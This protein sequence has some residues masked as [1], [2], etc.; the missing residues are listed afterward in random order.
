[1]KYL[2]TGGAG[3]IGSNIAEELLR[4]GHQVRILDN[5]STGSRENI[6]EF[7]DQI[8]LYEGDLRHFHNVREAVDGMDFVLHQGAL[9]SVPRS[10]S[11]PIATNEVNV[12]GTLNVLYAA[13]DAGVKRVV[14]A[15]WSGA[16]PSATPGFSSKPSILY[17]RESIFLCLL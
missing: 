3:F 13:K 9:P 12:T 15:S 6:S 1:M 7:I 17:P 8:E 14:M 4:R 16:R 5:F 11:D 2:I 10:I